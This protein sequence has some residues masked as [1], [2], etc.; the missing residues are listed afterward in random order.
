MVTIKLE[1]GKADY[2]MKIVG[3]FKTNIECI[4]MIS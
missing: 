4:K 3:R 2:S 1:G